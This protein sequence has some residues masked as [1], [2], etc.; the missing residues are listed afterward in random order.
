[1]TTLERVVRRTRLRLDAVRLGKA[2]ARGALIASVV[3][4]GFFRTQ[5]WLVIAVGAL[6]GLVA[7]LFR[8]RVSL[9]AAALFLDDR[10]GTKERIVTLLTRPGSPFAVR[11]SGEVEWARR[12]PRV[13][14]PREAAAVPAA[15]L[16]VF[17][18]GLLPSVQADE[19]SERTAMSSDAAAAS[20][21]VRGLAATKKPVEPDAATKKRLARGEAPKTA[22]ARAR[23]REAIE[24]TVRRPEDRRAARAKLQ[25]ALDGDAQAARELARML[26]DA[27]GAGAQGTGNSGA[28]SPKP[29]APGPPNSTA[30][31]FVQR[32]TCYPGELEF[33]REVWRVRT[34]E[35]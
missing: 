10:W 11:L 15:L 2:A 34:T 26:D 5:P 17:A 16:V 28:A 23:L 31:G 1:M 19:K 33:L 32:V 24:R 21:A 22:A 20:A 30:A 27:T 3:A 4:L 25:R 13:P 35:D 29:A 6:I 8:P 12:L 9:D 14:F 18:A 7:G